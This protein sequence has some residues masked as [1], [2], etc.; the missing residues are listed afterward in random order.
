MSYVI[1]SDLT[2]IIDTI[3]TYF[4]AYKSC[5][6]CLYRLRAVECI[7]LA[8]E[9]D[10][11]D[12]DKNCAF[13]NKTTLCQECFDDKP[14]TQYILKNLLA[15]VYL[16]HGL[17]ALRKVGEKLTDKI[18]PYDIV[19]LKLLEDIQDNVYEYTES[20]FADKVRKLLENG[21][22]PA[23][24]DFS[25][26]NPNYTLLHHTL[27]QELYPYPISKSLVKYSKNREKLFNQ[28]NSY[29]RTALGNE[30]YQ[31]LRSDY[32]SEREHHWEKIFWL[33][34][35]YARIYNESLNVSGCTG[36]NYLGTCQSRREDVKRLVNLGVW[37]DLDEDIGTSSIKLRKTNLGKF[38]EEEYGVV[39]EKI[40]E[41]F[42]HIVENWKGEY[43]DK[44]KEQWAQI[45]TKIV[46][47]PTEGVRCKCG[48]LW[49]ED[50]YISPLHETTNERV[51]AVCDRYVQPYLANPRNRR[52]VE[53]YVS[54]E[55]PKCLG[56]YN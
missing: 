5:S 9:E 15:K 52:Y 1:R 43:Y 6:Y 48:T 39:L 45:Q 11:S 17:V 21:S 16:L 32:D 19:L 41:C 54:R 26:Y 7:C 51:C 20:G 13:C 56:W 38:L 44:C 30:I 12:A 3:Q 33:L 27:K 49:L 34:D 29:G 23:D 46:H 18:N 42:K 14:N 55:L 47:Y 4:P 50:K 37:F 31:L 28:K 25:K 53:K 40:E 8:D 10:A 24:I 35:N 22:Y 36:C 2:N